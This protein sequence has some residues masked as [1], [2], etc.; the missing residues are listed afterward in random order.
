[1]KA[2]ILAGGKG[3]RLYPLNL[4][5]SKQLQAV[6]DKPMIY[7]SLTVLVASGIR[8]FCL[9]T[10]PYDLPRFEALLGDGSQWGISIEYREQPRPEGIAQAFL[11]AESF[12]GDDKVVLMLGDNIFSGGDAFPRALADFESGA[13]IFAYRVKDPQRYGV[14]E[15][16]VQGKALSIEEKPA[17]PRSNYAVPGVYIYDNQVVG[18]ARALRPSARHE[19]EITDVNR[20]YLELDQLR[21]HRLSRGFAWLDAGTSTALQEASSYIQTIEKRQD[22]KI[23]CPEEAALMRGFL[24]ISQFEALLQTMPECEYRAYLQRVAEDVRRQQSP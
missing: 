7:Y 4:V 22:V 21:V 6:Y 13:S 3:T 15:F 23:G 18:I 16:D 24:S 10:T 17:K 12:I 9:I 8:E 11:I 20:A 19:L 1:M 2:I 5:A 14:I